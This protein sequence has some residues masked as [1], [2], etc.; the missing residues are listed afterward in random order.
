VKYS[1]INITWTPKALPYYSIKPGNWRANKISNRVELRTQLAS[2][3]GL[4]IKVE[5]CRMR[6]KF[7]RRDDFIVTMGASGKLTI[8]VDELKSAIEAIKIAKDKL[9]I[10]Y[11]LT[12]K[13]T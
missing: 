12:H 13:L 9:N 11:A 8:T 6:R 4:V 10:D 7:N 3:T 1:P 2:F 5:D